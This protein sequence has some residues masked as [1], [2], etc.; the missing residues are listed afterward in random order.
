MHVGR[1]AGY[2][3]TRASTGLAGN[4]CAMVMSP[5]GNSRSTF[6]LSPIVSELGAEICSNGRQTIII[7][8]NL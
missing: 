3:Q 7:N 1:S 8:L 2:I 4:H 5:K 6:S